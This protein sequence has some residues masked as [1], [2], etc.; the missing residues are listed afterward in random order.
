MSKSDLEGPA[1]GYSHIKQGDAGKL[2]IKHYPETT[3]MA[4]EGKRN[5]I[6]GPADDCTKGYHK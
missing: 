2:P 6:E 3:K 4:T 1:E 5:T